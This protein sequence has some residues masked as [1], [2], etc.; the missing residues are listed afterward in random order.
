MIVG[1][2]SLKSAHVERIALARMLFR[3]CLDHRLHQRADASRRQQERATEEPER[4]GLQEDCG[5]FRK[6]CSVMS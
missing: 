5:S 6:L 2:Q 3:L 4:G 1:I